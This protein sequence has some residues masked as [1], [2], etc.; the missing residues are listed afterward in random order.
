MLVTLTL[1]VTVILFLRYC[2]CM[3][4]LASYIL[5]CFPCVFLSSKRLELN[6]IELNL[7]LW[8]SCAFHSL[9]YKVY[10][11][12]SLRLQYYAICRRSDCLLRCF[13]RFSSSAGFKF[14]SR[15]RSFSLFIAAA[16]FRAFYTSMFSVH[17][18]FG[19]TV[20]RHLW[21]CND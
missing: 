11:T 17:F 13:P 12:F 10:F 7:L 14:T 9:P 2:Y 4:P 21:P 15:S 18:T 8:V 6:W 1:L 19:F 16:F 20:L 5:M 3:S